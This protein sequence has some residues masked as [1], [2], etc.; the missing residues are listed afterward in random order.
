MDSNSKKRNLKEQ[1]QDSLREGLHSP[2]PPPPPSLT[3]LGEQEEFPPPPSYSTLKRLTTYRRSD[4]E[5]RRERES[6][7][8][9]TRREEE[10]KLTNV[11]KREVEGEKLGTKRKEEVVEEERLNMTVTGAEPSS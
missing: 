2:S 11:W 9:E 6:R 5:S 1:Q 7:M 8:Q 10:N 3:S 4:R